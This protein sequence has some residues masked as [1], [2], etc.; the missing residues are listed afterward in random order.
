MWNLITIS[1]VYILQEFRATPESKQQSESS[2]KCSSNNSRATTPS[3]VDKNL[4]FESFANNNNYDQNSGKYNRLRST[5]RYVSHQIRLELVCKLSLSVEK[6]RSFSH[7][8]GK[9]F[10]EFSDEIY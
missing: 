2:F 4:A 1:C 7:I 10:A 3:S 8:I 9:F 5:L 6:F